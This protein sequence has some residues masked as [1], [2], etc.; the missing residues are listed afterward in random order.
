[1]LLD[2]PIALGICESMLVRVHLLRED[3]VDVVEA[4][5]G[6]MVRRATAGGWLLD[7]ARVI[8]R[9]AES[10]RTP[11]EPDEVRR[12]VDSY[13][14]RLASV[15]LGASI[16]AVPLTTMLHRCGYVA[17]ARVVVDS[18]IER[19]QRS[20]ELLYVP[21]LLRVRGDII[22]ASDADGARASYREAVSLATELEM[23]WFA[24]RAA[25]RL[26]S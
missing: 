7:E 2:D 12:L 6:I 3:P 8:A 10:H 11:L 9:W 13:A 25:A 21:E 22:A 24:R 1:M 20:H 16:V 5:N 15:S 18:A 17:E 4:A 19:A 26:E 23:P 14:A